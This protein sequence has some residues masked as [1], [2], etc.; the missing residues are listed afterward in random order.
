MVVDT[1]RDLLQEA[2]IDCSAT[3]DFS[4]QA[5]DSSH[6]HRRLPPPHQRP[7]LPL[8]KSSCDFFSTLI[9]EYGISYNTIVKMTSA[10]YA[11]INDN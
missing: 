10:D 2:N 1:V 3:G 11:R 5:M 7:N 4:L 8:R 6:G 9:S